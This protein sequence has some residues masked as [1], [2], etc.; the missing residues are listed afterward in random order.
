MEV[1]IV[2][3]AD[4]SS[5]AFSSGWLCGEGWGGVKVCLSQDGIVRV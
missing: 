4:K 5:D 2:Y 3:T 1:E